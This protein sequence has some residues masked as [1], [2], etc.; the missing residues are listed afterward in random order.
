MRNMRMQERRQEWVLYSEQMVC[1]VSQT[2]I[3]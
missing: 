2:F 1:G 3:P